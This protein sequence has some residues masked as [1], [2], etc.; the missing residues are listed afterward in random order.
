[1][2][3]SIYLHLRLQLH[4]LTPRTHTTRVAPS[5]HRPPFEPAAGLTYRARANQR[6]RRH[7]V[8]EVFSHLPADVR[9]ALLANENSVARSWNR[10]LEMMKKILTLPCFAPQVRTSLTCGSVAR[11]IRRYSFLEL[12]ATG[13]IT[14]AACSSYTVD[15]ALNAA[16]LRA[17]PAAWLALSATRAL[18]SSAL[19]SADAVALR[20]ET[21]ISDSG[22]PIASAISHA[23]N[24]TRLVISA[25]CRRTTEANSPR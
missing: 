14:G 8:D 13:A 9:C 12:F 6:K 19:A 2:S 22:S 7:D 24:I 4:L 15:A 10:P 21:R 25:A 23:A 18:S 3:L 16:D 17:A 5:N 20:S 11:T 1:M